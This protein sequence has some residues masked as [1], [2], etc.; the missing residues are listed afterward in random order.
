MPIAGDNHS[1][2][3]RL[4][5]RTTQLRGL[6]LVVLLLLILILLGGMIWR[7][8]YRLE[9]VRAY[10]QY[11]HSIQQVSLNLQQVL[12]ENL[13]GVTTTIRIDK[14]KQ[15][16]EEIK[17]LT[18]SSYY[19]A[20][21]TPNQLRRLHDLLS[22]LING[23]NQ[24]QPAMLFP[25]LS[26]MKQMLDAEIVQHEQILADIIQ[27]TRT[28]LEL[29]ISTLAAIL[30]LGGWFLHRRLLTPLDNL[31][32]LLSRLSQGS[33]TPIATAHLDPLLLPV[34]N[35]YNEMVSRLQQLEHENR[36][37]AQSLE[38]KVQTAAQAL[39]EQH[40]SLARAER[41]AA[42]GELAASI[43]H[44]LRNP[45]AGIRMSCS[46]LRKEIKN[47]DQAQRLDLMGTE[48]K[49]LTRLLND[50]LAQA[51]H[52]PQPAKELHLASTVQELL[53]LTRYQ[54]PP[55]IKLKCQIPGT[56]HCRLP[57]GDFRQA[58]LNLV[59]NAAQ[60]MNKT[61]GT[62]C[63]TA[64]QSH[65]A[66][67]LAVSDEGPGFPQAI[68]DNGIRPFVSGDQRGTGLGLT[69]VQRF[70]REAGGYVQL[71]NKQPRGACVTLFLP[72]LNDPHARHLTDYRGRIAFRH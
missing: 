37:H 4:I 40:R 62:V 38:A 58:L 31:T 32:Q 2:V 9:T 25:A 50:L 54:I 39:L 43:A 42:V 61:P 3:K 20:A 14:L 35:S 70:A 22:T 5:Y 49:R 11:S 10:M 44:E 1:T 53:A 34:F 30:L 33:F 28:E 69:M 46:N 6:A 48:L 29:A 65:E 52:T 51:K 7:N 64:H 26:L 57:E 45:L 19:S 63:V 55:H 21:E 67:C 18:T 12:L 60:A 23:Q 27:D 68:I 24:T 41:L 56:L 59:L 17:N 36:L 71:T 16:K 66:L 8:L 15:L 72:Y 47:P 13:S